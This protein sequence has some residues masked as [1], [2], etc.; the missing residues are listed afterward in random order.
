MQND[1]SI[2]WQLCSTQ[3]LNT[4]LHDNDTL[5]FAMNVGLLEKKL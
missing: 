3:V 4:L 2:C 5:H 1:I